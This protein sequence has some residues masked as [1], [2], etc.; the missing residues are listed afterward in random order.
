M[1]TSRTP[2]TREGIDDRNIQGSRQTVLNQ[3]KTVKCRQSRETKED[4]QKDT[5]VAYDD[6]K[7]ETVVMQVDNIDKDV[8]T[9]D[10]REEGL[11]TN[12]D[13]LAFDDT[14]FSAED[15]TENVN[16]NQRNLITYI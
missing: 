14:E 13:D 8:S 11:E 2:G 7:Q 3:S 10:V 5:E 6:I 4:N 12:D 15:G 16:G 1:S 9:L